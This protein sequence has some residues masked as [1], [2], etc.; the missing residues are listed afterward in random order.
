MTSLE[1]ER[2]S[3]E[4]VHGEMVQIFRVVVAFGPER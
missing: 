1:I 3:S 2:T 4:I